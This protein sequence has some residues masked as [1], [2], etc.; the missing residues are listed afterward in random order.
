MRTE[1]YRDVLLSTLI[2]ASLMAPAISLSQMVVVQTGAMLAELKEKNWL[3][4]L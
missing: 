3:R 4:G 2:I 1:G